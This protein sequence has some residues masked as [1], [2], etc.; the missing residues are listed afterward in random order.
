LLKTTQNAGRVS[1]SAALK[2]QQALGPGSM[3]SDRQIAVDAIKLSRQRGD[4]AREQTR[5]AAKRV[6]LARTRSLVAEVNV[7]GVALGPERFRACDE[8][9]AYY[10]QSETETVRAIREGDGLGLG[11]V[12]LLLAAAKSS[13]RPPEALLS[14]AGEG[15]EIMDEAESA[16]ADLRYVSLF[17]KFIA[18]AIAEETVAS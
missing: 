1:Q 13:Q 5:E 2:L 8:L 6:V 11:E 17:L 14:S 9:I 10:T 12:A 18:D 4:K 7:A 3:L 15:L 16:G